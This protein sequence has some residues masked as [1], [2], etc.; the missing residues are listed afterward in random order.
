VK[1]NRREDK[2]VGEL[3]KVEGNSKTILLVFSLPRCSQ[4][5]G[6]KLVRRLGVGLVPKIWAKKAEGRV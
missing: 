2:E 5:T 4:L 1:R 3:K 6:R